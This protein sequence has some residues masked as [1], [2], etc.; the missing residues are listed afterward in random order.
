MIHRWTVAAL[1]L[2]LAGTDAATGEDVA[3]L[4]HR[5]D[6]RRTVCLRGRDGKF[7]GFEVELAEYLA[8]ELGRESKMVNRRLGQAPR[9]ARQ[10]ADDDGID[11]VLNGYELRETWRRSIPSTVPYYVYR[12]GLVI[13]KDNADTIEG[14]SDLEPRRTRRRETRVGVLGGSAAHD[15]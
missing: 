6:R 11:I 3:A 7:I 8:N 10:P 15:T 13:H 14:W 9:T 5:P 2:I 12:L 1:A 4:G